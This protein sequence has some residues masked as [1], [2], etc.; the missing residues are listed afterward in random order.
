MSGFDNG[1]TQGG[2]FSQTKQ[3]GAIL[4]GFGPPV[5]Q[6]GVLG[7]LYID[8]QTWQLFNKR[9]TDGSVDPWGH[10][11]FVVPMAYRASLKWFSASFPGDDIGV[12]GDFCL[13]WAGFVNYGMQPSVYGPKQSTSWPESG[14]GPDVVISSAT[15]VPVGISGEG[16]PL[17]ESNSTQL[18]AVGLTSEVILPVPVLASVGNVV[19]QKGLETGPTQVTVTLNPLYAAEDQYEVLGPGVGTARLP[20][21]A[22][23]VPILATDGEVG[24]STGAAPTACPLPSVAAFASSNQTGLDLSIFDY[25]G[26][27]AANN[28]TFTLSGTDVFTQGVAPSIVNDYG[29]VRLR[30]IIVPGGPNQW[31]VRSVG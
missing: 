13:L 24:I 18:I 14:N 28:V 15:V 31:F 17:A 6:S 27:A 3:F 20:A 30:P 5:P 8:A 16:T 7:D 4:R 23:S 29:S 1:T 10:Y 22:P 25:T 21:S 19:T 12:P 2:V 9:L 26:H 11:L